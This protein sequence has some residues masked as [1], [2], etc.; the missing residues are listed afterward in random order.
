M[1]LAMKAMKA[2]KAGGAMTATGPFSAVAEKAGTKTEDVK[3]TITNYMELTPSELKKNCSFKIG[4]CLNLK[5]K[6]KPAC[7]VR[8]RADPFSK[9][10][11]VFQVGAGLYRSNEFDAM[12]VIGVMT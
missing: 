11:C 6:N 5:V 8:K 10:P 4:G 12:T 7:P 2:T 1:A 9:E 3:A